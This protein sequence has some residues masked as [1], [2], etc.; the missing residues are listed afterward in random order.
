VRLYQKLIGRDSAAEEPMTA[1]AP[2]APV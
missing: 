2:A 1:E